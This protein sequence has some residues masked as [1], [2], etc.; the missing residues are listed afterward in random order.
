MEEP[1]AL[2]EF[3]TEEPV[4]QK[5]RLEAREGVGPARLT[6]LVSYHDPGVLPS[7]QDCSH[8][9]L[10]LYDFPRPTCKRRHLQTSQRI[11]TEEGVGRR[12]NQ[13]SVMNRLTQVG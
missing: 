9:S 3:Q 4:G 5:W 7:R 1:Q 10:S 8:P 12:V 11:D 13:V 6:Q 2:V